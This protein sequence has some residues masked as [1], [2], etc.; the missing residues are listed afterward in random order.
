LN[1]YWSGT[2][3]ARDFCVVVYELVQ[4]LFHTFQKYD[5]K[6]GDIRSSSEFSKFEK[7]VCELSVVQLYAGY[8][9]LLAFWINLFN[10]LV[11]HIHVKKK[12]KQK[13]T[14]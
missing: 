3:E 2:G 9:A 1:S 6:W 11:L 4:S 8:D 10:L 13:K 14:F 7:E 12:K 5:G